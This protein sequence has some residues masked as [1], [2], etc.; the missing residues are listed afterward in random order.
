MPDQKPVSTVF[1]DENFY[2]FFI[3]NVLLV[4]MM[5]LIG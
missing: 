5:F 4:F 2:T 1:Q 3:K